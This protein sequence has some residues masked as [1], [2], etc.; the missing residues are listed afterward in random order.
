MMSRL[1]EAIRAYSWLTGQPEVI[2]TASRRTEEKDS[3]G[4]TVSWE[5]RCFFDPSLRIYAILG[6]QCGVGWTPERKPISYK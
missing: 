4:L 3:G 2:E 1:G 6:P 5:A